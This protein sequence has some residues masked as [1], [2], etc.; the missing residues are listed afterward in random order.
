MF[1]LHIDVCHF[2]LE[3]IVVTFAQY[4]ICHL[5]T[6]CKY[7]TRLFDLHMDVCHFQHNYIHDTLYRHQC[8]IC[9]LM[10][11]IS[12]QTATGFRLAA[13]AHLCTAPGESRPR[14]LLFAIK[15]LF[16]TLTTFLQQD[17]HFCNKTYIFGQ[18]L[19]F[20]F[21]NKTCIFATKLY[22]FK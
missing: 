7:A 19:F 9:T 11:A 3:Y 6:L 18:D 16:A 1:D 13:L 21:C 20:F 15:S 5:K 10:C 14:L 17:L 12:S 2:K 8:S 4:S 22:L